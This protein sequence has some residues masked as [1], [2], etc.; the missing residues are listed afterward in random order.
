MILGLLFSGKPFLPSFGGVP[1]IKQANLGTLVV[2]FLR[3]G[4]GW[5]WGV[6][7]NGRALPRAQG[8]KPP[9]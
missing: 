9:K 6:F 7:L 3:E 4:F 5:E 8:G 1:F 2:V